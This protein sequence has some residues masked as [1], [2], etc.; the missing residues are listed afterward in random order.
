MTDDKQPR[1]PLFIAEIDCGSCMFAV[2]Q[3]CSGNSC[4]S[5]TKLLECASAYPLIPR[6]GPHTESYSGLTLGEDMGSMQ[7]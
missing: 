6:T 1:K 2:K 5:G 3:Q 4:K 7:E